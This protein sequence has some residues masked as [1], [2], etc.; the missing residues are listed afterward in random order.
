MTHRDPTVL[1][2]MVCGSV[3]E[4]KATGNKSLVNTFNA[5]A[6]PRFPTRHA[7]MFVFVQLTGG[8]RKGPGRCWS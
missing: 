5:I 7:R 8:A 1:A 3:I 4:D 2:L 6:A